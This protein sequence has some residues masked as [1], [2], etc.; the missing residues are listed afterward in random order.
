M[1]AG[2]ITG[3]SSEDRPEDKDILEL[4]GGEN[5]FKFLDMNRLTVIGII[6]GMEDPDRIEGW[7]QAELSDRVETNRTSVLDALDR[8]EAAVERGDQPPIYHP[9][10]S[11][12]DPETDP[13]EQESQDEDVDNEA[14]GSEETN[15]RA[16]H[17]PHPEANL[18]AGEVLVVDRE[19]STEYIWP[20]RTDADEPYILREFVDGTER[21]ELTLSA[22][23]AYD[24]LNYDPD[25][26]SADSVTVDAPL[27]AAVDGGDHSG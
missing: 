12:Y 1:S 23:Q 2:V 9:I 17:E 4:T 24:R 5:P 22:S 15:S 26:R 25:K 27:E 10:H 14:V 6:A 7:R 8:Q 16:V 11:M 19:D 3:T 20:A 13:L 21:Q 18:E